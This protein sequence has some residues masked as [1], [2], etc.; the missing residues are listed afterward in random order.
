MLQWGAVGNCLTH[1]DAALPLNLLLVWRIKKVWDW[2]IYL[3]AQ[4]ASFEKQ[5][6]S[7]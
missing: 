7:A 3:S 1:S 4:K 2:K 6:P 5:Q